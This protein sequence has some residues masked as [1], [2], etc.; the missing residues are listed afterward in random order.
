MGRLLTPEKAA[1]FEDL[2]RFLEHF[3]QVGWVPPRNPPHDT[4]AEVARI[5][6]Q[7]GKSKA[8]S[9]LR[10]AL[11]DTLEMT[12]SRTPAWVQDF[13]AK[14]RAA[15]VKTLSECRI[16]YWSKYKRVLERGRIANRE[17]FYMLTS[18]AN[19]MALP[20]VPE[21]RKVLEAMLADYE[22]RAA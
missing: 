2:L 19:D 11:G 4:R 21:E 10:Q 18:I 16:A 17:Q 20:L 5:E 15:G 9:G 14:C 12:S 1:E 6:A 22:R 3:D 8:L 13:D 7:F